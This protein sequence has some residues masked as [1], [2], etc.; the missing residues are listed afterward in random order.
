MKIN[1]RINHLL[2]MLGGIILL[3]HTEVRAQ[4]PNFKQGKLPNGLTYYL[5][6][7]EYS[8]G[9]AH[10]YLYQNVGAIVENE[11][12]NGLA[13][14]LE[15]MAFN[16]TEH[17][18]DRVMKFLRDKG[19]YTFNAKTGINETTYQINNIPTADKQL[20]E[21]M[22]LIMKDW[23]NGITFR[24]EDVEKERNI[25]I[26]E[27]RQSRNIDRRLREAVA[28]TLYNDT[29][30]AF[31]NVIGSEQVLKK[32]KTKDIQKFY[33]TWYKPTL[34]CIVV[35]GDI[36]PEA[37][38]QDIIRIFSQIPASKVTPNRDDIII[39]DNMQPRFFQFADKE[40]RSNSICL[41]QRNFVSPDWKK[42]DTVKEH[43]ES[44]LFR[45][46]V[47][48]RLGMIRNEDKEEYIAVS[49][50]YTSWVRSY[51]QNSW[52]I[53]P[54]K[55]RE[56][57]ALEQ[58]LS[59]RE[60]L[61]SQGFTKEEFEDA[62]W[63]IYQ[64][65]K[66][67]LEKQYLG[68]PDNQM[69]IFKQN[70]LYGT[71]VEPFRKQ[72]NEHIEKIVEMEVED[73]N[74]WIRS[75]MDDKNLAFVTCVSRQGEINVSPAQLNE[76]L[77][78]VKTTPSQNITVRTP[79]SKLIDFPITPGQIV[80]TKELPELEAK[81]WMLNNGSHVLYKHLPDT[82]G[83]TYFVGSA[84]GG[85]SLVKPDDLPSY[86]AMK[87]LIMQS[88]LS[89]YNRNQLYQWIKD[90]NID[91]SLSIT[92]YTDGL[93][94]NVS[95]KNVEDFF[96]YLYLVIT[97]QQFDERVF[98]KFV[99][100]KKYL[101]NNRRLTGKAAVQDSIRDLL[102][103]P[104]T[105]NPKEDIEFYNRMHHADLKR[106]YNNTFG[107]A[108]DFTFCL[109]SSLPEEEVRQLVEKYIASLPGTPGVA[110]RKY[111]P[112]DTS[113][114][115]KEIVREFHTELEG[116]AGEVEISFANNKELSPKEEAALPLLKELLQARLFEEL[117][118][119]EKGVYSIGVDAKYSRIPQPG[120]SLSIHFTTER[121]K[122]DRLKQR[123]YEIIQELCANSLSNDDFKKVHVP[124]I[125]A[126]ERAQKGKTEAPKMKNPFFWMAVLNA[127][128]ESGKSDIEEPSQDKDDL[129]A[130]LTIKD[131]ANLAQ[132]IL[133]G[134][135][136]RDI[137]VKAI[138]AENRVWEH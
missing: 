13:H 78:K 112:F 87:S 120:E 21:S 122:A 137:M 58:I 62:K 68:T 56:L 118:E 136:K 63:K 4:M 116:D 138:P 20:T 102:V 129:F 106:L 90:K 72:L 7:D 130:Q 42:R 66:S 10:F 55:G 39:P 16:A 96:G 48:Q 33:Q 25:I 61:R 50:D 67:L 28:P 124:M 131:V 38:E 134:A 12:Q 74:T 128:M 76:L 111:Q 97:G 5:S 83:K 125:M 81:E 84:M 44:M 30:Y 103:P 123:T 34:Q 9:E 27:W 46:L 23:C 77:V 126:Q 80:G 2:W 93:G 98:N 15:H 79:I 132:K 100:R 35:I 114:P 45:R 14:F 8:K 110:P 65:Y 1:N 40:N 135:K 82:K 95:S 75:W 101:Y 121:A 105:L 88:G 6:K 29:K 113:S 49:A 92:D 69:N 89:N 26:E 32:F 91:L 31:H 64:E 43:L 19:I 59:I 36:N 54:Y 37:Y 47:A 24:P 94:G 99:E 18:S 85:R 60:L 22:L 17:F 3:A 133:N 119:K 53:V 109:I 71:P 11:N 107:N 73:F 86:A 70:Y 115:E 41:Y 104:G 127:Y 108:A 57:Q 51:N 52:E 117:R